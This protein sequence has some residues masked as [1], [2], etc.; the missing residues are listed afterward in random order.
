MF[1]GGASMLSRRVL[2]LSPLIL[3]AACGSS[4]SS[5]DS[6]GNPPPLPQSETP[7]ATPKASCGPGSRPET[8]LQGRVSPE[9][10][11]SG[12]AAQ[13][14]TCNTELVGSYTIPNPVGTVA[15]FKVERY[16]DAAGHE[17]AY[18]DTTLVYPTNVFDMEAGVNVLD[19]ADPANPVRTDRLIR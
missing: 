5:S 1:F 4:G 7:A 17:C 19:M 12:R 8:G 3:L 6:S 10:H 9:D 15:G 2:L 14:F 18:Y 11:Q 16:V 13:G